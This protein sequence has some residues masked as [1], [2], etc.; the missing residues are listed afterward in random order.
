MILVVDNAGNVLHAAVLEFGA[1]I[2]LQQRGNNVWY[3]SNM[4]AATECPIATRWATVTNDRTVTREATKYRTVTR[5]GAPVTREPWA[6]N[7]VGPTVTVSIPHHITVTKPVTRQNTSDAKPVT[8]ERTLA[9][10]QSVT[11]DVTVTHTMTQTVTR[12]PTMTV[13]VSREITLTRTVTRATCVTREETVTP[14]VVPWE[15]CCVEC[16]CAG[17]DMGPTISQVCDLW[18]EP[19]CGAD[20]H[21]CNYARIG[22]E[23]PMPPCSLYLGEGWRYDYSPPDNCNLRGE[24]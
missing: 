15:P 4:M 2:R 3:V 20:P 12:W 13:T 7:W 9:T 23:C 6:T 8:R 24:Q 17:F 16:L 11:R 5:Y 14:G 21:R 18:G 1:P 22:P 10:H 19:A